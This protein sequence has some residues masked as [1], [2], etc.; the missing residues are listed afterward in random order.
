MMKKL[1]TAAALAATATA[2]SAQDQYLG[3]VMLVGFDFCPRGTAAAEGQLLSIAENTALF[4]LYGT[5]YGGDGRTT[6]ALPDLRGRAPIGRGA[7]PGLSNIP[8]GQGGGA[9]THTMSVAEMPSHGHDVTVTVN[10]TTAQG[11]SPSPGGNLP[12]LSANAAIYAPP[13][14]TVAMAPGMAAGQTSNTG[15]GQAFG[16]RDP[17]LAMRYCIV[18]QGIFPSRS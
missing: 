5:I 9:E 10:G 3:S 15:G 13:G 8:I 17:Y 2:A 18:T 12:A 11:N 7:G 14:T 1:L 6:F 16:L 4:S